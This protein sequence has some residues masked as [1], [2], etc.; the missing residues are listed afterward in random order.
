M[1]DA[2]NCYRRLSKKKKNYW[3]NKGCEFLTVSIL[4]LQVP[5]AVIFTMNILWT[6]AFNHVSSGRLYWYNA[7]IFASFLVVCGKTINFTLICLSSQSFRKKLLA[8]IK[9]RAYHSNRRG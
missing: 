5:S 7:Q 1:K 3:R 9:G 4:F 8:I 6:K 2:L